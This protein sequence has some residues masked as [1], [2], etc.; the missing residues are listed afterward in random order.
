MRQTVL[1]VTTTALL[2]LGCEGPRT[3]TDTEQCQ[4]TADVFEQKCLSCGLKCSGADLRERCDCA[5]VPD[6]HRLDVCL[7]MLAEQDCATLSVGL[8]PPLCLGSIVLGT[9]DAGAPDA[10]R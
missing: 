9:C 5:S 10:G 3:L 7:T 2:L 6:A 8:V 1:V 4:R